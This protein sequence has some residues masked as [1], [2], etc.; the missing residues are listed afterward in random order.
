MP[1]NAKSESNCTKCGLFTTLATA[2]KS[3]KTGEQLYR[4]WC[5]ACEKQRKAKWVQDNIEHVLEKT[6]VWQ[7]ANPEI[8]KKTKAKW[9]SNNKD[10]GI[11]YKR[12]YR[13]KYPE[14]INAYTAARRRKVRCNQPPWASRKDLVAFYEN[15]PQGYHVDHIIPLRGKLVSGLHV[16]TNLQ[17]L[18]AIE[19]LRKHNKYET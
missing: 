15:C 18:P 10:Y 12:E 7:E 16:V 14:R 3:R 17:Y 5:V 1:E 4:S 8:V 13:Q 19:N 9:A 6:R 2:N 11:Q